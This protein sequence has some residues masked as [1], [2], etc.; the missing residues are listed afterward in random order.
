VIYLSLYK[1]SVGMMACFQNEFLAQKFALNSS[2]TDE[3]KHLLYQTLILITEREMFMPE[4][5]IFCTIQTLFRN[6]GLLPERIL[7]PKVFTPLLSNGR[8]GTLALSDSDS[9]Y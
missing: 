8:M 2:Q 3:C 1:L 6:N 4:S 5:D 7:S 9:Y